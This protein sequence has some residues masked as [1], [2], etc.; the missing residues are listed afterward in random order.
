M[1]LSDMKIKKLNKQINGNPCYGIFKPNSNLPYKVY[2]SE[3]A[4]KT[5]LKKMKLEAK[6]NTILYK[7]PKDLKLVHETLTIS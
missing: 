3:Y 5:A 2:T 6:L 1:E 7:V 4:A